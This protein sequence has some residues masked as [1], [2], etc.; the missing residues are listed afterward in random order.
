MALCLLISFGAAAASAKAVVIQ[1]QLAGRSLS[2]RTNLSCHLKSQLLEALV[3]PVLLAAVG[4][5]IPP[6]ALELLPEG[7]G[8]NT[9]PELESLNRAIH[10]LGKSADSILRLV[11]SNEIVSESSL[12]ETLLEHKNLDAHGKKS[13]KSSVHLVLCICVGAHVG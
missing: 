5:P 7:D 1:E 3:P 6:P 13:L 2:P 10:Q 9:N 4:S 11:E 12:Q 8:S